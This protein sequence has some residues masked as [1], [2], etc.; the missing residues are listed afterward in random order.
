M[1]GAGVAVLT[2]MAALALFA[3][4]LAPNPPGQQFANRAYAPPMRV[5]MHDA[6]GW[7]APFVRRQVLE[8]RLRRRFAV[9][10]PV[11]LHWFSHGTFV[12]VA[13]PDGPLLLLGADA[14]GRDVLSRV[15]YGAR[16]SLGVSLAGVAGAL[17]IGAI[18]GGLA[19]TLGGR[20]DGA[21]M[22]V[23]DFILVLPAAYLVLVLRAS[24]RPVLTTPVVFGVMAA[25]FAFAAWPHV[26]RGVRAIVA[27]ERRCDYA[28]AARAAGAGPV[29]LMWQLLPASRSFLLVECVLLIP[30]LLAAEAT[31]SFLGLGFS[32]PT[33]SWGTM[34]SDAASVSLMTEAPWILTPAVLLFLVVLAVQLVAGDAAPAGT[35]LVDRA[36]RQVRT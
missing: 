19:G 26:A 10:E 17:L 23:A 1:R 36:A 30:A 14:L 12:S 15:L 4:V 27:G 35:L 20:I 9:A 18:I 6:A 32:E 13:D 31:I 21:L 28:E 16:L 11:A 3:S 22:F 33:P 5:Q 2:V 8:D 25:M 24:L 29:R 7:H 34:L